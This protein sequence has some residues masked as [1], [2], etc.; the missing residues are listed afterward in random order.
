[1]K[2][3][4]FCVSI[5]TAFAAAKPLGL[6]PRQAGSSKE[7]AISFLRPAGVPEAMLTII[8]AGPDA[9]IQQIMGQPPQQ[10]QTTINDLK[11]GKIPTIPGTTPKNLMLQFLPGLGV[12]APM[13]ELVKST[14]DAI[15]SRAATLPV[16]QLQPIIEQLKQG[17]IPTIPGVTPKQLIVQ[18]LPGLGVPVATVNMIGGLPDATMAQIATL[19]GAQLQTV[20]AQLKAG[21]I[22]TIPG[23]T[24]PATGT[25][26]VPAVA[27][28]A[29]PAAAGVAPVTPGVAPAGVAPVGAAP[30]G[31]A[32]AVAPAAVAPAA[33][34]RVAP[35]AVPA[36]VAP[37]TAPIAP[38][39]AAAVPVAA[40]K[41][42]V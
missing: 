26:A 5:F 15:M 12:P 21:Q 27:P 36:A 16:A 2:F 14:P 10:L 6:N 34:A 3:S 19:K 31:A 4:F 28:G 40:G 11:A 8:R 25:A 23:I 42:M 35:V 20:I 30:A 32:P 37:A 13:I 22:P 1:M 29:V 39:A 24:S 17:Q 33:V 38:A 41:Q 9:L 18:T 7:T